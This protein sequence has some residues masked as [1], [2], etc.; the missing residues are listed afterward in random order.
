[1]SSRRKISREAYEEIVD[2]IRNATY[3]VK[4]DILRDNITQ[5]THKQIQDIFDF[6][7]EMNDD[8]KW[9]IWDFD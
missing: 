1:M 9:E 6:L 4:D 2:R 5:D 7:Q 8:T 3:I